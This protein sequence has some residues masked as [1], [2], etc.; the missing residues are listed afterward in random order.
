M[1]KDEKKQQTIER[2]IRLNSLFALISELKTAPPDRRRKTL[3][4]LCA[5]AG[6]CGVICCLLLGKVF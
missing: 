4:L 1:T 2:G 3:A 6:F 5:V